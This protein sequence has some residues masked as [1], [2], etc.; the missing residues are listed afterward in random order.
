MPKQWNCFDCSA[1]CTFEAMTMCVHKREMT[2]PTLIALEEGLITDH[3]PPETFPA[4]F[5]YTEKGLLDPDGTLA[6][7]DARDLTHLF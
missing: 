2:C 7:L 6:R 4:E 3:V 1:Q 5:T